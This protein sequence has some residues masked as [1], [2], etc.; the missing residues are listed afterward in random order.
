MTKQLVLVSDALASLAAVGKDG[1][2]A[3]M[4]EPKRLEL[5]AAAK[6][7]ALTTLEFRANV[8]SN[9]T[10]RNYLT[11]R[12]QELPRFARSFRM[13][14]FL[15]DHGGNVFG[16]PSVDSRGGTILASGLEMPPEQQLQSPTDG[17]RTIK[18]TIEAVKPWAQVGV[19]DG[20]IDRFSIGWRSEEYQ[21]TLDAKPYGECQHV[22]GE[23]YDGQLAEVLCLG[24]EGIETSG[25]VT[26]AVPGTR[27]EEILAAETLIAHDAAELKALMPYAAPSRVFITTGNNAPGASPERETREA[28]MLEKLKKILGLAATATE[29]EAFAALEQRLSSPAFRPTVLKALNLPDTATDEELVGRIVATTA[30]GVSVPREEHDRVVTELTT[31]R[32]ANAVRDAMAAG[33]ITPAMKAWAEDWAQRDLPA[34][35]AYL[36][37]A[38]VQVPTSPTGPPVIKS[39]RQDKASDEE[40]KFFSKMGLSED[41][42]KLAK[43]FPLYYED[44]PIKWP[45]SK[46][47]E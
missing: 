29:E 19:L 37:N 15:R 3:P 20:T 25:V 10:N 36:A 38:P 6:A 13:Q 27:I 26:P 35:R 16:P 7:G 9:V 31:T 2:R 17:V 8:F 4:A 44:E 24:I 47:K 33:K 18:Q 34:F 45:A 46:E 32:A 39:E 43:K 12:D 1:G 5:L 11:F 21:C 14:P 28:T 41:E 40:R 30:P 42:A 22:P 23:M